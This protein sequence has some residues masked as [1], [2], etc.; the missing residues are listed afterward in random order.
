[1]KPS[2]TGKTPMHALGQRSRRRSSAQP[3]MDRSQDEES[4][5]ERLGNQAY[6]RDRSSTGD[7]DRSRV[8]LP[9]LQ[10]P[11]PIHSDNT[12]LQPPSPASDISRSSSDYSRQGIP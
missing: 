8:A 2:G 7:T 6:N 11:P 1:M 4:G 5:D 3:L 9:A 12:F 10:L